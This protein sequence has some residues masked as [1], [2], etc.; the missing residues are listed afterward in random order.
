MNRGS[1]EE[2]PRGGDGRIEA[3][4]VPDGERRRPRRAAAAIIASASASERAIGFSTSTG[5]P[6]SRNGSAIVAVQLGR[7]RERHGVDLPEQRRGSRTSGRV[8]LRRGDLLGAR[9][10]GVDDRRRAR[11]PAA[12][13]ESARDAARDARRR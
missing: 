2:R 1:V 9:A 13:T 10:I 5:M 11:R 8:P 12:T 3:L 4:G 7:H 6:A